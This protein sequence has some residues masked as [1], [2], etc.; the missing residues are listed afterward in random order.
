MRKQAS[1]SDKMWVKA[2]KM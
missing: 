1:G 2:L